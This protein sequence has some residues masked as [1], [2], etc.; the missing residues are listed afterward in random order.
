[1]ALVATSDFFV[2]L[3]GDFLVELLAAVL[4]VFEAGVLGRGVSWSEILPLAATAAVLGMRRIY[5]NTKDCI[6]HNQK[7]QDMGDVRAVR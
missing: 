7:Q 6:T 4:G 5:S 3:L 2:E 1:V